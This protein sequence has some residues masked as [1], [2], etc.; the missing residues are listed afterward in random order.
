[1]TCIALGIVTPAKA[2]AHLLL[3]DA[4]GPCLRGGDV[5]LKGVT[6]S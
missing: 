3:V 4:M 2:G 5:K 6:A 1:M